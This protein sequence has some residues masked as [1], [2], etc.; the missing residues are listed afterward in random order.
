[1]ISSPHVPVGQ[2]TGEAVNVRN[3]RWSAFNFV[4]AREIAPII[5][6]FI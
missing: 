2:A 4:I 5:N 1:M 6:D 3:M